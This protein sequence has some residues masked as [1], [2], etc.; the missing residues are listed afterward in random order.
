M[1]QVVL[2]ADLIQELARE[3]AE[4]EDD[5]DWEIEDWS[6]PHVQQQLQ[7][8]PPRAQRVENGQTSCLMLGQDLPMGKT[9]IDLSPGVCGHFAEDGKLV[10]LEFDLSD[11]RASNRLSLAVPSDVVKDAKASSLQAAAPAT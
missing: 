10:S 5:A 1:S 9:A 4:R 6:K 2:V 8:A 11:A 3:L 7:D